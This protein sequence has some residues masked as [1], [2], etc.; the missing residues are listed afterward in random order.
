MILTSWLLTCSTAFADPV[1]PVCDGVECSVAVK[2]GEIAPYDGILLSLPLA[3]RANAELD[4]AKQLV[5]EE[6]RFCAA[7]LTIEQRACVKKQVEWEAVAEERTA[8]LNNAIKYEQERAVALAK[9]VADAESDHVLWA[10][11]GAGAGV[12]V[13]AVAT[14][15]VTVYL[16]NQ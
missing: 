9:Q 16:L 4:A 14:A 15:A 1:E 8:T 12:L 3:K 13:G 7:R 5:K 6:E 10:L 2:K 11:G